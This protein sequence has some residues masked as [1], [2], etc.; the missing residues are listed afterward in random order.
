MTA[1]SVFGT[2]ALL[3]AGSSLPRYSKRLVVVLGV[4][5][6]VA[7][8]WSR[9]ALLDHVPSDVIGGVLL[10]AAWAATVVRAIR[11]PRDPRERARA[12]APVSRHG[13]IPADRGHAWAARLARPAENRCRLSSARSRGASAGHPGSA[14]LHRFDGICRFTFSTRAHRAWCETAHSG[15]ACTG[16]QSLIVVP[17]VDWVWIVTDCAERAGGLG[18]DTEMTQSVARHGLSDSADCNPS[19]TDV[20][21]CAA[22]GDSDAWNQLVDRFAG[23]VWAVARSY[24]LTA[25]DAADVSQTT[26]LRLVQHLDRIEQ[27]E[28]VGAWLAITARH[29][30]LRVARQASR[31]LPVGDEITIDLVSVSVSEERV[32][33]DDALLADERARG[34]VGIGDEASRTLS[35]DLAAADGRSAAELPRSG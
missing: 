5:L 28:R 15:S 21:R 27:P 13:T 26:W 34:A 32:S 6:P 7:V 18:A 3:A 19:L 4:T 14:P 29:E 35:A 23:M 1:A 16:L 10:G 20:V 8:A 17:L 22:E 25:A 12:S 33:N 11:A 30:A 9:L 31:Q 24:R 2:L